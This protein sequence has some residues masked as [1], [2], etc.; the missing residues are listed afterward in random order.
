[1]LG[2]FMS[3]WNF[4]ALDFNVRWDVSAIDLDVR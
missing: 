3:D 1:M 4:S 2:I